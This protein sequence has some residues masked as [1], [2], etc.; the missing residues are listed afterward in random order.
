[1][2]TFAAA[3][4]VFTLD[5][6]SKAA[7]RMLPRASYVL[8]PGVRVSRVQ[9][10]RAAFSHRRG[11]AGL[12]LSWVIAL[13]C[14]IALMVSGRIF[15]TPAARIGAGAALGGAFGNLLDVLRREAITDFLALGWWPVFNLADVGI[16]CG[17]VLALWPMV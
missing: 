5:V 17:L 15:E 1:M 2:L 8:L 12:L 16:V 10:A 11:R 9:F 3:S 7:V 6:A 14:A 13:A 4:L